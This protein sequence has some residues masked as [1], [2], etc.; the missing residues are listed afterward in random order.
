MLK[1]LTELFEAKTGGTVDVFLSS[2]GQSM[3]L[4]RNWVYT[5]QEALAE[6]ELMIV[7]VT[8]QSLRS[9]WIYFE[10]GFAYAKQTRVVPVGFL[11]V[12]ISVLPPPISLLQGFN[13]TSEDGLNNLIALVNEVFGHRHQSRFTEADYQALLLAGGDA[14]R[15]S[16]G[17]ATP[18]IY[19]VFANL[20][21]P[22]A[23]A[24]DGRA[25]GDALAADVQVLLDRHGLDYV[26][27]NKREGQW[28]LRLM[29]CWI[30]VEDR[31]G[32]SEVGV[33]IA[34]DPTVLG[35]LAPLLQDVAQLVRPE[36]FAGATITLRLYP[37]VELAPSFPARLFGTAVRPAED[38]AFRFGS[39][40]FKMWD[41]GPPQRAV[42]MHLESDAPE[43]DVGQLHA[44]LDVLYE[45]QVFVLT[46][47]AG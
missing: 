19:R 36:G 31:Q 42:Q 24:A 47:G 34:L 15:A 7:F 5:L 13:I 23:D 12:D 2:D 8:E 17:P 18:L 26:A 11:G 20:G 10:S 45:R 14:S 22:R 16:L 1:R 4:G 44:L 30:D 27:E 46:T 3:P 38:G 29:G 41:P 35:P 25:Q 43:L 33:D 28:M 9:N 40:R 39:Y 32:A 37:H 21:T 6:A